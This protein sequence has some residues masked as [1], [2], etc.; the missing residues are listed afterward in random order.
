MAARKEAWAPREIKEVHITIWKENTQSA[1][2]KLSQDYMMERLVQ[3]WNWAETD[4]ET[5]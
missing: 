3:S 5:V 2:T 1:R 4:Q